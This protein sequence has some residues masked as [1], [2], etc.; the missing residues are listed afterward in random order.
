MS[1]LV[2]GSIALDSVKTPFGEVN[3]ALGGSAV[4]FSCAASFFSAVRLVGVVGSDFPRSHIDLLDKIGVDIKGLLVDGGKTFRW[5]GNYDYDLNVA[6]TIYTHLNVFANFK[7]SIPVEYRDS[8][9]VFLANIDPELQREV[10][11]QVTSP[12]L[13]ACDSMNFW[14]ENKREHLRKLL[15]RVHIFFANDNEARQFSGE[16]N[17]LKAA[18]YMLSCGPKVVLVKK[19]EHG[20]LCVSKDFIFSYPAYILED[21]LDPT[22]A[23]DTF[24]GG[25]IGYLSKTGKLSEFVLRKAVAYGTILASYTVEDF[26]VNRLL[27]LK[28]VEIA[29]RYKKFKELMYC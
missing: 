10:L 28:P 24:A 1:L 27:R 9:N 20:A 18:R 15:R 12:R 19:G 26:S 14:I 5:K 21:P 22:G 7:P 25:F 3:E 16:H 13:I 17:L 6:H 2:V 29:N 23:G 4:Y 8:Q 11:S